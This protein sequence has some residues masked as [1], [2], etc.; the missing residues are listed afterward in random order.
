MAPFAAEHTAGLEVWAAT[1]SSSVKTGAGAMVA[2]SLA[3]AAAL[4]YN[5]ASGG[6]PT[7]SSS[8]PMADT[9]EQTSSPAP[10]S[11]K[12]K[13][14]SSS[15]TPHQNKGSRKG[16]FWSRSGTAKDARKRLLNP[17]DETDRALLQA[18]SAVVS[19]SIGDNLSPKEAGTATQLALS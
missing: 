9:S 7:S 4:I 5:L 18:S 2:V 13:A 16:L 11:S 15:R 17:T 8:P 10:S 6:N 12:S 3:T 19:E 14:A 1:D